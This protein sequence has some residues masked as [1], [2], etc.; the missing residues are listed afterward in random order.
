MSDHLADDL[1]PIIDEPSD[2]ERVE[3]EGAWSAPGTRTRSSWG[4]PA[5]QDRDVFRCSM[6]GELDF[7]CR[8]ELATVS[9]TFASSHC[10]SAEIDVA[11]VTF[12]DSS[13]LAMRRGLRRS[14]Q[15][16]GG[17]VV[18]VDPGRQLR[19]LLAV[20]GVTALFGVEGQPAD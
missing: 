19:R 4:T 14:A 10:S 17:D 16:G 18:L 15:D 6:Q 3:R 13:A 8:E 20:A 11:G 9:R 1:T 12:V 5:R 2:A 7:S